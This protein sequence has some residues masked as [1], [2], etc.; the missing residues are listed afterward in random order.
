[1]D[2]GMGANIFGTVEKLSLPSCLTTAGD[3]RPGVIGIGSQARPMDSRRHAREG[4]SER[5]TAVSH[6]RIMPKIVAGALPGAGT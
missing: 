6:D 1:V 3:R 2:G 5:T 4:R